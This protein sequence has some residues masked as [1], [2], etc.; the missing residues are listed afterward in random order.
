MAKQLRINQAILKKAEGFETD[1]AKQ[2][3]LSFRLRLSIEDVLRLM[4]D[5]NGVERL[6]LPDVPTSTLKKAFIAGGEIAAAEI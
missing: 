1:L 3:V 5:V 2:L 6:K 4:A